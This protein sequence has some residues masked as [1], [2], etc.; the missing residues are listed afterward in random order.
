MSTARPEYGPGSGAVG[1]QDTRR[2]TAP[3]L[4]T[5]QWAAAADA[6]VAPALRA[7]LA[8]YFESSKR[9]ASVR[10]TTQVAT[11]LPASSAEPICH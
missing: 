11:Q 9:F 6:P 2:S 1:L 7:G 8:E 10:V 4:L 5:A 3:H